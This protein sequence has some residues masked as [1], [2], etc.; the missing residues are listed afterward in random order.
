MPFAKV[1]FHIVTATHNRTPIITPDV[2][3][4]LYN[5]L[6][7]KAQDV[8]GRVYQVGGVEDH[9][10]ILATI[11]RTM[12]IATFVRVLKSGSCGIVRA[13]FGAEAFRWQAGYGI[14]SL[15]PHRLDGIRDYVRNQKRHHDSGEVWPL[16]ERIRE[17]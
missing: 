16:Y 4:V 17:D 14:L 10:H 7:R 6:C 3:P 12:A 9:V 2:E 11:P 1:R 5:G 8:G 13:K 15:N